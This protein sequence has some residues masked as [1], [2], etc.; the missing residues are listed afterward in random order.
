M[1]IWLGE[2]VVI[3]CASEHQLTKVFGWRA[4]RGGTR[5]LVSSEYHYGISE[6]GIY[7]WHIY[8]SL[9]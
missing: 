6:I 9:R 5:A 8:V 2:V 3:Y 7:I 1:K 4:R